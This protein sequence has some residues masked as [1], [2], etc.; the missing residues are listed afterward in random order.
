MKNLLNKNYKT[1][2]KNILIIIL[3]AIAAMTAGCTSSQSLE[4]KAQ[5]EMKKHMTK[6]AKDPKSVKIDNIETVY[7]DDSICILNYAFSANNSLKQRVTTQWEFIYQIESDGDETACCTEL[8]GDVQSVLTQAKKQ[9]QNTR[10]VWISEYKSD[11]DFRKK[12]LSF[13]IL[14]RKL[15]EGYYV[16]GRDDFYLKLDEN[17][18]VQMYQLS[19][20]KHDYIDTW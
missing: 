3:F 10:D 13:Q 17:G 15:N 4:K 7:L 11:M 1:M 9:Y 16:V 18:K 14:I 19:D 5:K 12:C 8:V 2:K 20:K 6:V